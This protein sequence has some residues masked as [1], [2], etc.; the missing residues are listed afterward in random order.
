MA[1]V[2]QELEPG[3]TEWTCPEGVTAVTVQYMDRIVQVPPDAPEHKEAVIT[4]SYES[5]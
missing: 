5:S 1:T 4:V 2:R 3:T